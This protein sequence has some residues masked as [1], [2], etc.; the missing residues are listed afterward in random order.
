MV[1]VTI[2][3]PRWGFVKRRADGRVDFISPL[4]SLF[5][6]GCVEGELS[7]DG[8][9]L[10]ALL[11]GPRLPRGAKVRASVWGCVEFVDAGDED[12]KLVCRVGL[13]PREIEWLRVRIFF[14]IYAVLK[15]PLNW[16]RGRTGPT[17]RGR[18]VR[19][20]EGSR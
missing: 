20:G 14:T 6:Y 13:A 7:G 10:D 2:E 16:V 15:R 9:P 8:D 19:Y 18:I 17:L 11:L 1:T 4:P 12:P 5:N 3:T